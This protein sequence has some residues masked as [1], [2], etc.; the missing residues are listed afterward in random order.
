MTQSDATTVRAAVE[1]GSQRW[2][3]AFN[4]GDAAGCAAAYEPDAVMNAKPLGSF[5]GRADIEAFW[6]KLIADGYC[7]VEYIDPQIEILDDRSAILSAGWRMNKAHGVIT[8]ELWVIQP[9]GTALLREDD[10]EVQG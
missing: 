6:T 8:K 1:A 10:F 9:D 2:K 4:G 3:V 5:T 7:D